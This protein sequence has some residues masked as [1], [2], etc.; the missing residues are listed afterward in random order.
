MQRQVHLGQLSRVAREKVIAALCAADAGDMRLES[1]DGNV[2][3][4]LT[5]PIT[6]PVLADLPCQLSAA[7]ATSPAVATSPSVDSRLLGR[8]GSARKSR[9]PS[10]ARGPRTVQW[11]SRMIDDILSLAVKFK[12]H[13]TRNNIVSVPDIVRA[14]IVNRCGVASLHRAAFADLV[15]ASLK[16][17]EICPT[18]NAFYVF[19]C[20]DEPSMLPKFLL[21]ASMRLKLLPFVVKESQRTEVH[22][23][24]VQVVLRKYI[25]LDVLSG[26][27]K[28]VLRG[29]P[30]APLI[31]TRLASWLKQ[32]RLRTSLAFDLDGHVDAMELL[33]ALVESTTAEPYFR[34]SPSLDALLRQA[35]PEMLTELSASPNG[36]LQRA[37]RP[38]GSR[39]PETSRHRD[40]SAPLP[41]PSAVALGAAVSAELARRRNSRVL[42]SPPRPT[43]FVP[44]P[45]DE[46]AQSNIVGEV[47][48][49]TAADE[50]EAW[51]LQRLSEG[52]RM[53]R[54]EDCGERT[55]LEQIAGS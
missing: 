50:N 43:Q 15:A 16:F 29:N 11:A 35:A 52:L 3:V 27:V 33:L 4:S 14:V 47:G 46:V 23:G 5:V 44:L 55:A 36:T 48:D 18:C 20:S 21:L 31:K 22:R 40:P 13:P 49:E 1:F 34:T 41:Q 28:A 42:M 39:S 45:A 19:V 54:H 9:S 12:I 37:R 32:E 53:H 24:D 25:P 51:L 7:A 8:R 2:L 26:V 17:R 30:R 38:A 6:H 10:P